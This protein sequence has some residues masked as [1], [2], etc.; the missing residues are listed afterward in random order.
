MKCLYY[1][2][3]ALNSAHTI[4]DDLH[5]VGVKDFYIHVISK[6]EAGL[7]KKHIHSSNYTGNRSVKRGS[8]LIVR[9]FS[10]IEL[11]GGFEYFVTGAGEEIAVGR[12]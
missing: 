3:P 12:W 10:V 8:A 5:A 4:S 1:L 9:Y 2:T 6:D 11:A 7:Q